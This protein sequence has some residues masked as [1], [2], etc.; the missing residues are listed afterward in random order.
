MKT[1]GISVSIVIIHYGNDINNIHSDTKWTYQ[2]ERLV[3][4]MMKYG[5]G[6]C[7]QNCDC[8]LGSSEGILVPPLGDR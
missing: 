1:W 7:Y 4:K 6:L 5:W 8:S 2:K 3:V